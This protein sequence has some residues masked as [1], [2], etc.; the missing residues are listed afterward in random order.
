MRPHVTATALLTLLVIGLLG[1]WG[2]FSTLG[3]GCDR[4]ER[5]V[6]RE[7]P[8]FGD[9]GIEPQAN[10]E[11]GA[12]SARYETRQN[13]REIQSYYVR[14]LQANGWG[15]TVR[16]SPERLAPPEETREV[17][18]ADAG[19][20]VT[21]ERGEYYYQVEYYSLQ[22]YIDPRPGLDIMVHVGKE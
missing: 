7:F 22:D 2:Y 5:R 20:L 16:P 14:K 1:S 12:C 11:T 10:E 21:A 13:R 6:Y 18:V 19:S 3:L 17:P 9:R 8:Q 15:I 4:G